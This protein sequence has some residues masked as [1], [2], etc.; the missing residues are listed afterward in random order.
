MDA[1]SRC[2]PSSIPETSWRSLPSRTTIPA[3]IGSALLRRRA[4]QKIKHWLNIHQRERAIEIGR[5]LMEREAKKYRINMKSISDKDYDRVSS[6]YGVARTDDL[7][8]G[9]GFGR[10]SARQALGKLVPVKEDQQPATA[11]PPEPQ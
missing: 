11:A 8:A 4:R 9:I 1:W 3:A 5:K 6:D 2:E 10:F 7:M